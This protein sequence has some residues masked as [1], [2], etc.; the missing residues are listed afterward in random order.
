MKRLT[1]CAP[2]QIIFDDKIKENVM[3]GT[4]S[5]C[6]LGTSVGNPEGRDHLEDLGINGSIILN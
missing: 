1:I 6:V 5:M 4:Y 2:H 3:D